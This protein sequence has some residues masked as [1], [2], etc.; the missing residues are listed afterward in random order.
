MVK[1]IKTE[2]NKMEKFRMDN[3]EGY[4]QSQLDELNKRYQAEIENIENADEQHDISEH[5]LREYDSE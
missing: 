1:K 3:T 4:T 5:V 2:N